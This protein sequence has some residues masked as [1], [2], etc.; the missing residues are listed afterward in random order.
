LWAA[1][2]NFTE[3]TRGAL[4]LWTAGHNFIEHTRG[5]LELWAAGYHSLNIPVVHWNCGCL[6]QFR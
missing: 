5:A 3:R 6:T 2:H 4:E 1:G